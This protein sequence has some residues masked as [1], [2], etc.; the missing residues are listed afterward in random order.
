MCH[1]LILMCLSLAQLFIFFI[2]APL[3]FLGLLAWMA[4]LWAARR[5]AAQQPS[6]SQHTN[7]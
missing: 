2:V 4:Y 1:S 3:I 5:Y 7:L 6:D